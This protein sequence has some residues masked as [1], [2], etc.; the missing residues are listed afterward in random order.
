[1]PRPISGQT[2]VITGAS[3]GIGRATALTFGKLGANVVLASRSEAALREVAALIESEGSRAHVVV[4]D[5]SNWMQVEHLAKEAINHF[6]RV[7]TWVNDASVAIYGTIDQLEADEL[8]QVIRVNLLGVMFGT[9]AILPY[10][11]QQG[12]GTII[13]VASGLGERSVPLQAAYSASKRGV[14][15]FSE[16]IRMELEQAQKGIT[17]TVIKPA[18]INTPFFNHARSKTGVKPQP[19]P[20]VYPPQLVADSIVFAAENPRRDLSVGGMSKL[21]EIGEHFSPSLNDW[22]MKAGGIMFK[23]QQTDRP[24]DGVDNLFAGVDSVGRVE[25]DFGQMTVKSSPYTTLLEQHPGRKR[26]LWLMGALGLGVLL[27]RRR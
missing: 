23:M 14:I 19:I 8:E 2:V 24:D 25:G 5:V 11:E 21:V 27:L 9:K 22:L 4:T 12:G 15:G 7:D 13:N 20:P 17:I 1:M 26:A 16:G 6:G 10:M 18:S 3:S